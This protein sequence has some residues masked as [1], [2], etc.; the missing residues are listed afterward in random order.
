MNVLLL[1][2][3]HSSRP[4]VEQDTRSSIFAI[5]Q[6]DSGGTFSAMD[7]LDDGKTLARVIELSRSTLVV[8]E[9]ERAA[10]FARLWCA[11]VVFA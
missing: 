3:S 2:L 6:D 7:E 9:S 4:S 1:Q 8:L 5:N 10:P 11:D